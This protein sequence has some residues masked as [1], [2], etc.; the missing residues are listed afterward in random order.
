[1]SVDI[2]FFGK[3]NVNF[4]K[5]LNFFF[6]FIHQT[7]IEEVSNHVITMADL[8][9][10][11][12]ARR[13]RKILENPE[14]RMKRIFGGEN[15]HEDHL[16]VKKEYA[17]DPP[18]ELIP[19]TSTSTP[20]LPGADP[21]NAA[22]EEVLRNFTATL[23]AGQG[24]LDPSSMNMIFNE[25]RPPPNEMPDVADPLRA[26][27]MQGSAVTTSP[28]EA[29]INIILWTVI[30]ILT[31]AMLDSPFDWL[32][33]NN[34]ALAAFGLI[35]VSKQI[36]SRTPVPQDPGGIIGLILKMAG[37]TTRKISLVSAMF[38][39]GKLLMESFMAYFTAFIAY[40]LSRDFCIKLTQHYQLL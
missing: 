35:F 5:I 40:E 4:R 21:N 16:T 7:F 29:K 34:N 9:A 28:R 26:G 37:I 23:A 13:Q 1:M 36:V 39:Y 19:T 18:L 32:V 24:G 27:P 10:K 20:M 3:E 8:A 38:Y 15:Y 33:P 14:D 11:R 25:S 2:V 12:A 6:N 30:G 31:C 22:M 17:P